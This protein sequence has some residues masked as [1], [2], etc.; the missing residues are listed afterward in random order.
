MVQL[1]PDL[2]NWEASARFY[3]SEQRAEWHGHSGSPAGSSAGV[4]DPPVKNH[5]QDARA[6]ANITKGAGHARFHRTGSVEEL[7]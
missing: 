7:S 3:I 6:T 2:E 5:A 1:R 4:L